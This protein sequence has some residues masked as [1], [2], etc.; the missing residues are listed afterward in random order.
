[1]MLKTAGNVDDLMLAASEMVVTV[2]RVATEV[3]G[4]ETD[5]VLPPSTIYTAGQ[6]LPWHSWV[7]VIH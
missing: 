1:M 3:W 7:S 2:W 6:L 4:L 5:T